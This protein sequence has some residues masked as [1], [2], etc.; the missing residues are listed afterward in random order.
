MGFGAHRC[1][2][3]DWRFGL[4]KGCHREAPEPCG[5][6]HLQLSVVDNSFEDD[7]IG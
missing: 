7:F 2:L 1:F 6:M 5:Q 3:F 4:K